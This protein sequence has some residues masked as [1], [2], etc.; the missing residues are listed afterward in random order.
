MAKKKAQQYSWMSPKL[1]IRKTNKYGKAEL[2]VFRGG[3]KQFVKQKGAGYGVFAKKP[4]KKGEMLFVMGGYILTI[5]DENNLRGIVADKPIEISEHFSIGPRK[6]SDIPRMPQ[7]YVNHSCKPNAGFKGQLF[8]V[9]LKTI[10]VGEEIAYD[11]AMVMH[12][13]KDSNGDFCF[14]CVCGS[15]LCRGT[16]SENDWSRAELQKRYDGYFQWYLQEKVNKKRRI[17]K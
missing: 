5:K 3:K 9:A 13:N 10:K 15:K 6:P 1:A 11:Y 7:H 17:R 2:P 16:I 14:D 12:P 4:I 8:M